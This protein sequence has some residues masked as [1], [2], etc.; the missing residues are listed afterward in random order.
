LC[1]FGV[2]YKSLPVKVEGEGFA[3]I[4]SER[5]EHTPPIKQA[6]VSVRDGGVAGVY[7]VVI[8][9]DQTMHAGRGLQN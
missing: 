7:D 6:C 9:I 1:F 4:D 3:V 5:R 2:S 8:V